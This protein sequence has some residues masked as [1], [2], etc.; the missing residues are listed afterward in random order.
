MNKFFYNIKEFYNELDNHYGVN[1]N[2]KKDIIIGL[3]VMLIMLIFPIIAVNHSDGIDKFLFLY[4]IFLTITILLMFVSLMI[5]DS[6]QNL[7][8]QKRKTFL[9]IFVMFSMFLF[10]A[11]TLPILIVFYIFN[12]IIYLLG[13]EIFV[14]NIR[15]VILNTTLYIIG[16]LLCM[17]NQ[18]IKTYGF[19]TY[20][21]I[22]I[23]IYMIF[24]FIRNLVEIKSRYK[25]YQEKYNYLYKAKKVS[26][27][28]INIIT[29]L[30]GVAGFY[31]SQIAEDFSGILIYIIMP[32]IIFSCMDQIHNLKYQN[33]DEKKKF[34]TNLYEEL[35]ILKDIVIPQIRDFS[36]I[37]I[38]IKLS[39]K[40]WEIENYKN[41]F[42]ENKLIKTKDKFILDTLDNCK[43][44][45]LKEYN[46]SDDN[47]KDD[48]YQDISNNIEDLAKC[49][50]D[51]K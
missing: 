17:V 47:E 49:L 1:S 26:L 20:I 38:R 3:V 42:L 39:I 9:K 50:T 5:F 18:K 37:K 32:T 2:N 23:V 15:V 34:I 35:V 43:S 19:F 24:A 25:S 11:I 6:P 51:G 12:F 7:K 10:F 28:I 4:L 45:L 36:G 22:V 13:I 33:M 31:I 30:T 21:F 14:R 46:V 29:M 48:F 8:H 27:Y 40:P 44:M 16:L 41:Y